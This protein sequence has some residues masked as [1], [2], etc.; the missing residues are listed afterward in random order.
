MYR[1]KGYRNNKYTST[2]W[3]FSP[4]RVY[5]WV[6]GRGVPPWGVP[7]PPLIKDISNLS[8]KAKL[9]GEIGD[10]PQKKAIFDPFLGTPPESPNS[11]I[12]VIFRHF[13]HFSAFPPIIHKYILSTARP[14]NNI[15]DARKPTLYSCILLLLNRSAVRTHA[16]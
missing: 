13:D 4:R 12:F 1:E 9:N 15:C 3:V 14:Q 2:G 11:V 10:V 7:P 5:F 16:A 6:G 8:P